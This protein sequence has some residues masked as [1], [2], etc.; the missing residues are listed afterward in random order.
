MEYASSNEERSHWVNALISRIY[1]NVQSSVIIKKKLIDKISTS[2]NEKLKEKSIK[3]ILS[4]IKITKFCIGSKP[5]TIENAVLL[6]TDKSTGEM[7]IEMN[8]NYNDGDA[9]MV[10]KTFI[11]FHLFEKRFVNIPITITARLTSIKG[12]IQLRCPPFPAEQFCIFFYKEPD[13]T[14][15]VDLSIGNNKLPFLN[16]LILSRIESYLENR[17]KL[18]IIERI[19]AP[20]RRFVRIP[21]T[22]KKE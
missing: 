9:I 8:I 11:Q 17:L 5:P 10:L 14:L 7:V 6:P 1:L 21:T 3:K 20:Q 13:I 22:S 16:Q 4:D 15:N 18:S 12:K 2:F 19:V